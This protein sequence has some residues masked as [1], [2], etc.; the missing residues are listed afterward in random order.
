MR[1]ELT[2][3]NRH[4]L[5]AADDEGLVGYAISAL[6]GDVLDLLRIAVAA[7]PAARRRGHAL[8]V[9]PAGARSGAAGRP[10]DACSR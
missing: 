2:G 4:A 5:V 7:R 10:P 8:L 3:P 9:R 1:T 6:S